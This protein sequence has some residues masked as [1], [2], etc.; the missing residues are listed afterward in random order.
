VDSSL[1]L[2]LVTGIGI[3][4]VAGAVIVRRARSARSGRAGSVATDT[5]A[6]ST[7]DPRAGAPGTRPDAP[8]GALLDVG[9][10]HLDEAML[11]D[12][13]NE[14]AHRLLGLAPGR[15]VGRSAMQAFLDHRVEALLESAGETGTVSGEVALREGDAR[16]LLLRARHDRDRG[17]WLVME[18]VSELRRLQRIRTE[19]IGNLSHE[20]RTPLTTIGLLAETLARDAAAAGDAI[21]GRMRDRIAKIEVET[22]NLTQMVAEMLDLSRIESGGTISMLD[23]VDLGA[24]AVASAERLRLFAERQDVRL[25]VQVAEDV[26]TIHGDRDRLGQVLLNLLHNAVKFSPDGG[27]VDVRVRGSDGG[28]VVEVEDHGIGIVRAAQ[29]RIFERFYKADQARGRGGGTGLGLSIARHIVEAH[30]GRISVSSEEGRGSTFTVE[31]P[32]AGPTATEASEPVVLESS[33]RVGA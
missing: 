18:D 11:I 24:L 19:F 13:A 25:E 5:E 27:E 30:G 1:L 28:A 15:L 23:D 17:T 21:P 10:V 7:P 4:L 20:L 26:P 14:A 31:F 32:L 6:T 2:A 9:I 12:S 22:E 16:T 3:G 8:F 33:E 29:S